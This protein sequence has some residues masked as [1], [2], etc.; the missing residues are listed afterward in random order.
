MPGLRHW[1][2]GSHHCSCM[3]KAS[4]LT[5]FVL[6]PA[7]GIVGCE[8]PIGATGQGNL[9]STSG[10]RDCSAFQSP[11]DNLVVD[12]YEETFIARPFSGNRFAGWDVCGDESSHICTWSVAAE[13]VEQFWGDTAPAMFAQFEPVIEHGLAGVWLGTYRVND[14]TSSNQAIC[15][16]SGTLLIGCKLF[17]AGG[18]NFAS[19]MSGSLFPLDTN[20][21][22]SSAVVFSPPWES[23][24]GDVEIVQRVSGEINSNCEQLSCTNLIFMLSNDSGQNVTV[25]IA[26]DADLS[27]IDTSFGAVTGDFGIIDP[28]GETATLSV[29]FTGSTFIAS[30]Q[31][32]LIGLGFISPIDDGINVQELEATVRCGDQEV[33]S[34]GLISLFGSQA[35]NGL[36]NQAFYTGISHQRQFAAFRPQ[37]AIDITAEGT[38]QASSTFESSN[39]ELAIDGSATTS[40]FSAGPNVNSDTTDAVYTWTGPSG[41]F[42]SEVSIT[43]NAGNSDPDSIIGVGFGAV[44]IEVLNQGQVVS[45]ILRGLGGTP[46]PATSVKPEM[47]GDQVRLTFK[48][49]EDASRGGFSELRISALR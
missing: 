46:D 30:R 17:P 43:G 35:G 20:R 13:Q 5:F 27:A 16:I 22:N 38:V 25:E 28:V 48:G 15:H 32:I 9:F 26:R 14:T 18:G 21:W 42:I 2:A 34:L 40:W 6:L 24:S 45:S 49:H 41:E 3:L 8:H 31:C 11:C 29:F 33:R 19:L 12:A 10:T 44:R 37:T 47:F 7:A 4:L 39:A 36:A 23:N 1:P